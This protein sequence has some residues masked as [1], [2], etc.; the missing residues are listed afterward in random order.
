MD[1][2]TTEE[3]IKKETSELIRSFESWEHIRTNGCSDP[4]WPDGCNMNLERNHIIYSKRRLEELCVGRELPEAYFIPTP[5]RVDDNYMA[6]NGE[7]YAR[8]MKK[9]MLKLHT[10]IVT[11]IP[12]EIKKN[13]VLF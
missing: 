5:E 4:S 3:L 10:G 12:A 7:H 8:R 11:K 2:P 13:Q 9:C 6:P 1:K